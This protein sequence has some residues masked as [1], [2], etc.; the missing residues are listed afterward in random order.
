MKVLQIICS[1]TRDSIF[2]MLKL[3]QFSCQVIVQRITFRLAV[4]ELVSPV[5]P[6]EKAS[7]GFYKTWKLQMA[8]PS[9]C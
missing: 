6:E 7:L 2:C 4:E 9:W 5:W 3:K 1:W 8:F